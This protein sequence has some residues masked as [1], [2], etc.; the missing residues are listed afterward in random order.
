M[1]SVPLTMPLTK[2]T[3]NQSVAEIMIPYEQRSAHFKSAGKLKVLGICIFVTNEL[4]LV[5]TFG[6]TNL[7]KEKPC[8]FDFL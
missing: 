8:V 5:L 1:P 7:Y 4:T 3:V 6:I 2:I